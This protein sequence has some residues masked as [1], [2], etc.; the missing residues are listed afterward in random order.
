M[1]KER[2]YD[3]RKRLDVVHKPDRRDPFVKAAVSEVEITADWSIVLGQHDNAFIRRI[4]ADLQD[5][6]HTSM[7]VTVNWIDSVGV[8]V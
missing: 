4:A 7:N 6:L 3:F 5:Y 8:E 2:N 1:R